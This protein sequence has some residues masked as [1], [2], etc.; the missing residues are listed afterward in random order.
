[1][2]KH[3]WCL[4]LLSAALLPGQQ[5][6]LLDG[7]GRQFFPQGFVTLTGDAQ[8]DL[9]YTPED[10]Q[11]M[12]RLGANVQ[13]IRLFFGKIG[14]WPGYEPDPAYLQ[15]VSHMVEM[16]KR[17]G[18]G[19]LFKL[20]VYDVKGF[21]HASW[22]QLW[23]D[24]GGRQARLIQAWRRVFEHFK[25]DPGVLGYDLIN[26]PIRGDIADNEVFVRDYLFPLYRRIIDALHEISPGKWALFQP[27]LLEPRQSWDFPFGRVEVP[28][29]RKNVVYAPHYYGPSPATAVDRYTREAALS[30]AP[31][32]IAE[33]GD[34]TAPDMD[35]NLERQQ[36]YVRNFVETVT[37]FDRHALGG[38]KPWFCG[39]RVITKSGATWAAFKGK[40]HA[41][42]AE[43]K[44]VLDVV[45]RPKPHVV[46][47]Q[48]GRY[49][50]NFASREFQLVL[51]PDAGKG[52]SEIYVPVD[53]HYPDGFHLVY[54]RGLTLALRPGETALKV[55]QNPGGLDAAAWSWNPANQTLT[56]RRW[57]A[58]SGE[59]TLRILPGTEPE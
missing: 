56:V 43:R 44:Y 31:L 16:G 8:G 18:I 25:S 59:A 21:N 2:K 38:V 35:R 34:A 1:M 42:G 49:E 6:A 22:S 10:Y 50:F 40:S 11:H 32:M 58:G 41:G 23:R 7:E 3:V 4:A 39:T 54:S 13:V 27:P 9:Q 36:A 28:L 14:A 12:A 17:A 33:H 19:S 29:G 37:L 45:A 48:V 26:E 57:D 53:R 52:A 5:P 15:Q 46:A 20:T 47:G 55:L 51:T 24:E 30:G